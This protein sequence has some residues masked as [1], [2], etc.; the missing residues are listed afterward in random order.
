MLID[1]Y[2]DYK[3]GLLS[4]EQ[5]F[6]LKE[7]YELRAEKIDAET[8]VLRAEIERNASGQSEAEAFA[9]SLVSYRGLRKLTR[10]A[11]TELVENIYVHENGEIDL[12]LRCKDALSAAEEFL[13]QHSFAQSSAVGGEN[14]KV[15]I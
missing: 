14:I 1:L 9:Q 10:D 7:K 5:Y 15:E 13:R 2:P 8:E 12:C 4:R 3:N 6:A 11:V